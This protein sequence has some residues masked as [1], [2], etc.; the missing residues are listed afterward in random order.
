MS[1]SGSGVFGAFKSVR[2]AEKARRKIGRTDWRMPVVE[3]RQEGVEL[4]R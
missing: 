4:F 1:G 2:E 3:S